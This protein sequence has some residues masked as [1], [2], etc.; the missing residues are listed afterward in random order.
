MGRGKAGSMAA[1]MISLFKL[2]DIVIWPYIADLLYIH[3]FAYF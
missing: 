2:Y 1:L 3:V